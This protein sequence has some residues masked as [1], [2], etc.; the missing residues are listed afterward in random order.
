M[1]QE[2]LGAIATN[3]LYQ[4]LQLESS[5]PLATTLNLRAAVLVVSMGNAE[6][7]NK[8]ESYNED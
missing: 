6:A 4:W 8:S 1:K 3:C 2:V 7:F 5:V